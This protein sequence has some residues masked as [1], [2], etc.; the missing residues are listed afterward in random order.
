MHEVLHSRFDYHDCGCCLAKKVTP[1][2]YRCDECDYDLCMQCAQN[3][4]TN[5]KEGGDDEESNLLMR[6]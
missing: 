4:A 2:L 1:P 5:E 6:E 3:P